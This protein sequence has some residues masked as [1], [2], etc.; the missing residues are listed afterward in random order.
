MDKVYS[1]RNLTTIDNENE[2]LEKVVCTLWS[3]RQALENDDNCKT[4]S[5]LCD[6]SRSV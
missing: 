2:I 6:A 3:G 4:G 5:A 1:A